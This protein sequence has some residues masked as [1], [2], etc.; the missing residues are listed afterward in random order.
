[1]G[2]LQAR[3]LEWVAISF[4]K[5]SSQ[6]RN[7]TQVSCI[8][9]RFF[10]DWATRE[11]S[12]DTNPIVG[13]PPSSPNHLP[14]V[15][16]SK[17][18]HIVQWRFQHTGFEGIQHEARSSPP[19]WRSLVNISTSISEG[20]AEHDPPF[21]KVQSFVNYFLGFLP[22]VYWY[23]ISGAGLPEIN[24]QLRSYYY[25]WMSLGKLINLSRPQ[26]PYLMKV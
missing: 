18:H 1:M 4:S 26:L 5:G 9:G 16:I 25:L 2:I 7:Q 3:I 21:P 19:L 15:S 24:F 20:S 14:K 6:P 22:S 10:T 23:S 17:Y 8:A 11:A 13:A 12:E